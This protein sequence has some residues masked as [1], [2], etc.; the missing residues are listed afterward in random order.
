[1]T[2]G[3]WQL[4]LDVAQQAWLSLG[5]RKLRT[6]LSVMGIAIGIAAVTLIGVVTQGGTQMVF[7]ELQTFGLRTV[8]I[9]R[10]N[11][12]VDPYRLARAGTGIDNDDYA[13]LRDSG[14][15]SAFIRLTPI[16]YGGRDAPLLARAGRNYSRVG[17]E[18]VDGNYLA[19]NNDTIAGGRG[20]S[21]DDIDRGRHVAIIGE[22]VRRELFGDRS[23]PVGTEL[24]LGNE[25]FEII[26]VLTE[27]DR[28]LLASIGSGGGQNTNAR[29]L[30]PYRRVQLMNG[31]DQINVLQGEVDP[32]ARAS[33]AVKQ[34]SELLRR[35]HHDA[36]DYRSETM[37]QYVQ[38]ANNILGGVSTIG[39][40]AASVSL[41]V[42]GLGILNIMSTSVLERTREIGVR[43]ALGGTE[44]EILLQFL[45]EATLISLLGGVA[46]LVL[47]GLASVIITRV[48]GFP[49][50]PSVTLIALALLVA[51][52]VGLISGLYPAYRAARL[53]PVEALRYE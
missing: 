23:N 22:Q 26:G 49:L 12:Q 37:E 43:K 15:C 13:A 7:S 50:M 31:N 35:R 41:L 21:A 8:W 34:A 25:K 45:C 1:M 10:D 51:V 36:F 24:R 33:V 53:R 44:R 3:R 18:G 11:R 17:L 19:I 29:L 39:V 47:G 6:F 14:C 4:W 42:A 48:T 2:G 5:D 20:F 38:T 9:L 16:V 32:Q 46:G 27:K 30:V 28:S 52:A 40:V